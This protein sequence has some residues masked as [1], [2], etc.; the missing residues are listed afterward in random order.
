MIGE[1]RLATAQLRRRNR[2]VLEPLESPTTRWLATCMPGWVTPDMLTGLGFCGAVIAA[3][4]YA[5]SPRNSAMLWLASV[6]LVV[7]W[8]GDSVDGNLARVR[9]IERPAYGFFIDNAT[10]VLEY[11]VF[12]VGLAFS[13]YVHWGLVFATL[14][15]FYMVMSLG[16]IRAQAVNVFD[17]AFGGVGLTEVRCA[18]I[19]A[20]VVMYYAPPQEFLIFGISTTYPNLLTIL[21]IASQVVTFLVVMYKTLRELA[22]QDPPKRP[23]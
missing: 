21:W 10:D 6:G 16:L 12:A 23:R 1:N 11:A 3:A 14:A 17:I 7:N 4:G 19:L 15:A 8:F 2:S 22:A 18:F 20:N 9:G 5:L 13:G